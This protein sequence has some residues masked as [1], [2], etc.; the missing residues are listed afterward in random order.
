MFF[1]VTVTHFIRACSLNEVGVYAP[2]PSTLNTTCKM[3]FTSQG[4]GGAR[5]FCN[6]AS[7]YRLALFCSV[8]GRR[9]IY[10][11]VSGAIV[12]QTR[13][14]RTLTRV[15]INVNRQTDEEQQQRTLSCTMGWTPLTSQPLI[16]TISWPT[17]SFILYLVAAL[18]LSLDEAVAPRGFYHCI[19]VRRAD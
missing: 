16:W 5:I 19:W 2:S 1:C 8:G 4:S 17:K 9:V 7:Q 6:H 15:C 10:D 14:R 18:I 11:H 12:R 3:L 13:S